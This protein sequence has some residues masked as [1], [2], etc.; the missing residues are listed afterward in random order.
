MRDLGSS[1][2]RG[3]LGNA[4]GLLDELFACGLALALG[5]GRRGVLSRAQGL[6]RRLG[7]VPLT[8][9]A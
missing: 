3:L 6:D 7:Q 2:P 9:L 1:E 5:F 8:R 4:L